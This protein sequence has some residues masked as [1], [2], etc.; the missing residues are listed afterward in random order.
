MLRIETLSVRHQR[1]LKVIG[2]IQSENVPELAA[3]I[4]APGARAVIDMYEVTL[5]DVEVVRFLIQIESSGTELTNCPSYVRE[6]MTR[7]REH[8]TET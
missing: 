2:R 5:V 8:T 3:Q 1:V 6:W 4:A 7:E